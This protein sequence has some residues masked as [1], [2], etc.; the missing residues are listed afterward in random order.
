MV[1]FPKETSSP[2][3]FG[4]RDKPAYPS[5]GHSLAAGCLIAVSESVAAQTGAR[6]RDAFAPAPKRR[7]G[8][9]LGCRHTPR[10]GV[11][12]HTCQP[13]VVGELVSLGKVTIAASPVMSGWP[14]GRPGQV[15]KWQPLGQID[16]RG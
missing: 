8:E 10:A 11:K 15:T 5:S 12:E 3:T 6:S 4:W 16:E 14:S 13:N 9:R 7:A 1:T 2:T